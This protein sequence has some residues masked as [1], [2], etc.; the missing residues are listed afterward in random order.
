VTK[1]VVSPVFVGRQA[2]LAMLADAFGDAA[3]GTP[4]T[5]LLGA[6]AGCGKSRLAAEFAFRVRDRALVLAGGCVELATAGLPYAPFT[7]ALRQLVRERG[8]AQVASL[9]PGQAAGELAVLLPGFGAPPRGIDPGTARARLFE[10][11]L[12]LLEGLAE[13]QPV[14]LILEDVHWADRATCDLLS[15]LARNLRQAAVLLV[16]TFRS[17]ELH[18]NPLLRPLLAALGRMGGV[19]RLE[20]PRLSRDEV[21]RQA[22][23]ILGQAP[24]AAV[25]N[26]LSE[27]GGGIPLFTEALLNPDGTLSPGLPWLLQDL[28]LT[29]VQRLP[30]PTQRVL[31]AAAVGGA[32]TQHALLAAVTGAGEAALTAALRPAVDAGV[33]VADTAGYTFRHDLIRE[34]VL[35]GILPAERMHAHRAFAEALE[36]AAPPGSHG[37]GA[38]Q[39]ALHWRGAQADDRALAAAWQ[40]AAGS[41]EAFAYAQR[42]LMLEQVLDL[43]ERV[44]EAARHT[45][46]D[47]IGVLALAAD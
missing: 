43:W 39:L 37:T 12:A 4:G 21:A 14:V 42:L 38:V 25:A 2:E 45:G 32:R 17:D 28:L 18:R 6:E 36:A 3:G 24:T 11:V 19:T 1:G 35:A 15:F 27:R 33:L 13:R 29:V 46:T 30:E 7:A 41:G 9:L 40:A 44:P 26:A 34:A 5:V 8:A 10:L 47:H 20:L 31:R 23:G 16:V 22:A